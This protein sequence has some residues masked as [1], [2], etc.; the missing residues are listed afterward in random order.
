MQRLPYRTH[1]RRL[2]VFPLEWYKCPI[3]GK[4][5]LQVAP[6]AQCSGVH[7]KCGKCRQVVEIEVNKK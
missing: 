6:G 5:L 1:K 4:K 3:C 7:I 2:G